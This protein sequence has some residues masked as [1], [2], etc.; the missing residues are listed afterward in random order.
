VRRGEILL[1][2]SLLK[3]WGDELEDMNRGGGRPIPVPRQLH[4]AAGLSPRLLIFVSGI[5]IGEPST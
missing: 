4:Q 1:D 5:A 3:S 2:L